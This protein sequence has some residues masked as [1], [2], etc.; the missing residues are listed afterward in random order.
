M[1]NSSQQP[2][3][4]T[5]SSGLEG[6]GCS[7]DVVEDEWIVS[8][9]LRVPMCALDTWGI[10]LS[11]TTATAMMTTTMAAHDY[12][13]GVSGGGVLI[14]WVCF[15]AVPSTTSSPQ[16]DD[17]DTSSLTSLG[18]DIKGHSGGGGGGRRTV[19]SSAS[20]STPFFDLSVCGSG[21]GGLSS[22]RAAMATQATACGGFTVLATDAAGSSRVKW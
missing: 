14:N 15:T 2:Q 1:M 21:L 20:L 3:S 5:V 7:E 11:D 13:A 12:S 4:N 10:M 19:K 18:S 16:S 9:A 22:L 6:G 17:D 8:G